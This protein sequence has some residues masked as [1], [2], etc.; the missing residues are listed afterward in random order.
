MTGC[1]AAQRRSGDVTAEQRG[2][3]PEGGGS[4]GPPPNPR[5]GTT[6]AL[7]EGRV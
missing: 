5:E 1:Q 3:F 7:A 2:P 4:R 6:A